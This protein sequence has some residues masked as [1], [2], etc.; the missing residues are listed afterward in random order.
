M[1]LRIEVRMAIDRPRSN[2]QPFGFDDSI[3]AGAADV[4]AHLDDDAVLNAQV[5][6]ESR[7][8]LAVDEDT[9]LND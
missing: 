4:T 6:F 2:D 5:A 3:S 8:F 1:D 9:V 7:G